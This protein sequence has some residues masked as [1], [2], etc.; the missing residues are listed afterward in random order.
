MEP[1]RSTPT[2]G[3]LE[4]SYKQPGAVRDSPSGQLRLLLDCCE[5][6]NAFTNEPVKKEKKPK[7]NQK[8]EEEEEEE[9]EE[10][11]NPSQPQCM[12]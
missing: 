9:E 2:L 7:R 12:L 11:N 1:L 10:K 8:E 5:S 4:R 3:S 6:T